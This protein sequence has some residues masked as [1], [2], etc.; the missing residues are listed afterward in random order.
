M[1]PKLELLAK[2]SSAFGPSGCEDNVADLIIAELS[3]ACDEIVRDKLGSVIAKISGS[4]AASTLLAASMDEASFMITSVEDSGYLKLEPLCKID[5]K[6]LTARR[7]IVGD[8]TKQKL[9]VVTSKPVHLQN[10]GDRKSAPDADK[11][12]IDL[13]VS[14][15]DE[16][17]KHADK[18]SFAVFNNNF[19]LRENS[20]TGKALDSRTPVALV[21]D[22]AKRISAEKQSGKVPAGDVYFVFATK[23]KAGMSSLP[24][25][26]YG[27]RPDRIIVVDFC[28]D[29]HLPK[30]KEHTSHAKLGNGPFIPLMDTGALYTNMPLHPEI[31]AVA[32][33]EGIP[34][35]IGR[36][37]NA[38][39]FGRANSAGRANLAA[40]G[41]TIAAISVPIKNPHTQNCIMNISDYQNTAKLL[42]AVVRG[43]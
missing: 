22:E 43:K 19:V 7:L 36:G 4:G 11:V 6:A 27:I 21:I 5:P 42:A 2:L 33:R 8:E 29:D 37:M 9:G 1:L 30:S 28:V 34:H 13:G 12:F 10:D 15:K 26:S 23:E 38:N 35:Q 14:T 18:G 31:L 17:L 24:S 41:I 39:S 25:A 16:A 32:E 3:S 20:A 40:D